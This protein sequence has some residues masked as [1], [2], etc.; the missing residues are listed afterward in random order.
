MRN[1]NSTLIFILAI[2]ILS[3]VVFVGCSPMKTIK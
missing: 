2:T 1:S 3:I